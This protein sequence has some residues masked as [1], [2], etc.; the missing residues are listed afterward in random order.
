[1][2]GVEQ[3]SEKQ[4]GSFPEGGIRIQ[5]TQAFGKVREEDAPPIDALVARSFMYLL[6]NVRQPLR[7]DRKY[8]FHSTPELEKKIR[9]VLDDAC[10]QVPGISRECLDKIIRNDPYNYPQWPISIREQGAGSDWVEAGVLDFP[11]L[12]A[13]WD[14][15]AYSKNPQTGEYDIEIP[16]DYDEM[17]QIAVRD[18]GVGE[19]E[20]DFLKA[21][22][23]QQFVSVRSRII[24]S[25]IDQA[26]RNYQSQASPD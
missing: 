24:I 1:M 8:E 19:K 4:S 7:R 20:L 21:A 14:N 16:D 23:E 11:E 26:N 5:M 2:A 13:S 22:F 10:A 9:T 25:D 3:K 18:Y 17:R 6:Q 12:A 15:K